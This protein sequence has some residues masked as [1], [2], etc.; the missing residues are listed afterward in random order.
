MKCKLYAELKMH[1]NG[2]ATVT[3]SKWNLKVSN[4]F[5]KVVKVIIY[6]STATSQGCLL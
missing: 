2:N 4:N 5:R 3:V 6:I 1:D